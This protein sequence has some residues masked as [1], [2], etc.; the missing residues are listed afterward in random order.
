[1]TARRRPYTLGEF[2]WRGPDYPTQIPGM[3]DFVD[4][5]EPDDDVFESAPVVGVDDPWSEA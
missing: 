2:R 1:M 4:P 3:G 5:P